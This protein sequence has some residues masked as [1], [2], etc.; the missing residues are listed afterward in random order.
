MVG[1]GGLNLDVFG[2]ARV[3]SNKVYKK[4]LT[5]H[6]TVI[7]QS[8]FA[9]AKVAHRVTQ[10][11]TGHDCSTRRS[12]TPT[13][14]DGVGDVYLGLHGEGALIVASQD[15]QCHSGDQVNLG[16]Q[17]DLLGTLAQILIGDLAVQGE[18]GRGLGV[19]HGDRE[20]HVE[21]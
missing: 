13:Q 18:L 11:H 6:Q 1:E 12:Q 21:G 3:P 17:A 8:L 9:Q 15:V 14:W 7:Q 10:H 2:W 5:N 4:G 19:I 20:F 16:V